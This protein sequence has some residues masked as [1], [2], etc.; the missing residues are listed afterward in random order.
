LAVAPGDDR[1]VVT[2]AA[3]GVINVW[4]DKTAEQDDKS[5]QEKEVINFCLHPASGGPVEL[6]YRIRNAWND[7]RKIYSC[8]SNETS[9]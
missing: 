3:D 6:F 5:R 9:L 1:L 7:A 4:D 8:A 2:G